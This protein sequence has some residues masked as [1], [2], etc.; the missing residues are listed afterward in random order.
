MED[1]NTIKVYIQNNY[2]NISIIENNDCL[3]IT[4]DSKNC[5][6]YKKLEGK[7]NDK[8]INNYLEEFKL[9]SRKIFTDMTIFDKFVKFRNLWEQ[10][11]E[12]YPY[13]KDFSRIIIVEWIWEHDNKKEILIDIES[14]ND[15]DGLCG[16]IFKD[17]KIMYFN[18]D[19]GLYVYDNIDKDLVKR[20]KTFQHIKFFECNGDWTY[21]NNYYYEKEKHTHQ[22]CNKIIFQRAR[23]TKFY[24]KDIYPVKFSSNPNPVSSKEN[25]L[26]MNQYDME[27]PKI[28]SY[29]SYNPNCE[30]FKNEKEDEDEYEL[31][32]VPYDT[33]NGIYKEINH[34]FLVKEIGDLVCCYKKL[35]ND[36]EIELTDTDKK[37]CEQFGIT[38]RKF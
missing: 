28:S 1:I 26:K 7:S 3:V 22:Y 15:D 14:Y 33:G 34:G 2:P 25:E 13:H 38:Y 12:R 32:V 27:P 20:T 6:T 10:F 4:N 18:K 36:Q 9:K 23:V 16:A 37:I 24:G 21:N 31:R 8:E 30:S 19:D 5:K 17:K 11:L 35:V 29:N